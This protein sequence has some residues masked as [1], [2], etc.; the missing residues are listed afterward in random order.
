MQRWCVHRGGAG[1]CPAA[2]GAQTA[3]R[4]CPHEAARRVWL[5]RELV[6]FVV[7]DAAPPVAARGVGTMRLLVACGGFHSRF[8]GQPIAC[9][10]GVV[11]PQRQQA[12]EARDVPA[13][14]TLHE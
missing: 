13:Q 2:A 12:L 14:Q 7:H 8:E 5:A 6:R 4:H 1:E 9:G 11:V 3:Q 10:P